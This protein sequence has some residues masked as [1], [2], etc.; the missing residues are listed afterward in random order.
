MPML[1]SGQILKTISGVRIRVEEFLA[2]GGQGEVYRVDYNGEKKALKWYKPEA[3]RDPI[4]FYDNLKNNA[5][6]GSPDK[7]FLWPDAVTEKSGGTFGYIMGL[8]PEGYYELSKILGSRKCNF[9]SFKAAAE[10]CIRI[11][12]AFRIL[13][14]NGYSY[15][16]LNDGNFFINPQTGDVL[17]CDTDNIAKNGTSTGIL[18]KPRYMAPEIVNGKGKVLPDTQSDRYSLA[19]ILFLILFNNHPLE[20][21]HWVMVTCMTDD[22]AEKLYGTAPLF[23][24]DQTNRSNA[25]V[26]NLQIS[27]IERWAFMPGYLKEKFV[28]AFSQEALKNP[29]KRLRELDWLQVLVRFRSDI[30]RCSC[31]NEVFIQNAATTKCDVCGKP[32]VVTHTI[33]LPGYSITA[34]GGSRVYRCMLG[35]CNADEALNPV[36]CVVTRR[37][38]PGVLGFK[39][40]S[41]RILNATTPSGKPKQIKPNDVIPF[42]PGI[43][44]EAFEKKVELQ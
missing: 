19:A 38:K 37:D 27:V 24:F 36:A 10:A 23:I 12:S 34:A 20:G 25:P 31:G 33:R 15:Q 1:E 8:R 5:A 44:I 39:N 13:H 41:G 21:S 6:K 11:V 28:T 26:R 14:N 2:E 40:M 17:I 16:D 7:A 3:L 9:V 43:V 29:G 30:V 4:L 22:V 42:N 35:T 18:G 32:V